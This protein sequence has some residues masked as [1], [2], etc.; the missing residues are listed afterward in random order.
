LKNARKP[1]WRLRLLDLAGV[2]AAIVKEAPGF[3]DVWVRSFDWRQNGDIVTAKPRYPVSEMCFNTVKKV[4]KRLGGR[5]VTYK[6]TSYFELVLKEAEQNGF[7]PALLSLPLT[8]PLVVAEGQFSPCKPEP[9]FIRFENQLSNLAKAGR[10]CT[11][12]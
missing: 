7:R 8:L 6:G 5:Y 4:F 10:E 3:G 2:K 11:E 1:H 9:V 12:A